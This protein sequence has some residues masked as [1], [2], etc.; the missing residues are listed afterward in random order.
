MILDGYA[1]IPLVVLDGS[2]FTVPTFVVKAG[3]EIDTSDSR[4]NSLAIQNFYDCILIG[5]EG[6]SGVSGNH[7]E[8]CYLGLNPDGTATVRFDNAAGVWIDHGATN[9]VIG[10]TS[11][12]G[13]VIS[14]NTDGI[15]L[16]G[17]GTSGNIIA[18]NATGNAI[19]TTASRTAGL[20]NDAAG[21]PQKLPV[22]LPL[23]AVKRRCGVSPLGLMR[24]E[25]FFDEH[26]DTW[27][28]STLQL[29]A[30]MIPP[31]ATVP[32]QAV[33]EGEVHQLALDIANPSVPAKFARRNIVRLPT[34]GVNRQNS[35]FV[36]PTVSGMTI[37]AGFSEEIDL[38][39][40]GERHSTQRW[41]NPLIPPG[42]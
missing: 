13:N 15:V 41:P 9:N 29:S 35:H 32:R 21:N 33:A 31:F 40:S 11:G 22:R 14:G 12:Q 1:G 34:R 16:Q 2:Q 6:S 36:Q 28:G 38:K 42:H 18:G 20:G 24:N 37:V 5:G 3:L 19:G 30:D 26:R 4:I 8:Y 7:I 10:G 27:R 17:A 23:Y 25:T 39:A